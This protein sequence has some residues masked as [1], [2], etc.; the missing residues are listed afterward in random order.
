MFEI[1]KRSQGRTVRIVTF[2]AI[3]LIAV[4]GAVALSDKLS[5]YETTRPPLLRFGIPTLIVLGVGLLVYR[6]VNRPKSADFLIATE[7]EMKKV[8][9]SSRKEVIGSTKVVIITTVI[10]A[11]MLLGVDAFFANLFYWIGIMGGV[12]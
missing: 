10:L 8:S 2:V 7:S 1:Y 9:W 12:N 6:L 5:G 3:L 4:L 11:S